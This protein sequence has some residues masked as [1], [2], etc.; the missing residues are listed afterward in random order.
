MTSS[1]YTPPPGEYSRPKEKYWLRVENFNFD[2]HYV[3][4]AIYHQ[5]A[6]VEFAQG[7]SLDVEL[8]PEPGN[9]HDRWAVAFHVKGQRIGY[10]GSDFADEM[11]EFV[12]GH[13]RRGR[14]VYASG[15][16]RVRP[17]DGVK[18][19][20][21]FLPWWPE[22]EAFQV[23][24]GVH[25]ECDTL[26]AL[27]TDEA[28]ERVMQTSQNLSDEDARL[29]RSKRSSAPH[30]VWS[31]RGGNQIPVALR[32]RLIDLDIARKEEERRVRDAARELA[33]EA[34][35]QE[36]AAKAEAREA[37]DESIRQLA[38]KGL[39]KS[40]IAARLKCSETK[41][42]STLQ[43][44]GL[45]AANANDTSRN[46][47][48][49]R[50]NHALTLQKDGFTR[51]EI[52]QAFDCSFETVKGLLKD[53]K[54]FE[55]PSSDPG[56]QQRANEVAAAQQFTKLA[57]AAAYLGWTSKA[58]KAARSDAAALIRSHPT[59]SETSCQPI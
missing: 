14:A 39:S 9:P 16:A 41:V 55:D 29:I 56:R 37:L 27:L 4:G 26:L 22:R 51:K 53:A 6:L 54:F 18:L 33:R 47:R 19:A 30:L 32:L 3:R 17:E 23:D 48:L 21:V 35:R 25:A 5:P 42:R 15:E 59:W 20:A 38:R 24:S 45:T 13:N 36:R 43:R 44:A 58:V 49:D 50:A 46:E 52:A 40:G 10:L 57:D 31:K 2:Y 1:V 8:V 11:H 28:R 7:Q 34:K 12:A